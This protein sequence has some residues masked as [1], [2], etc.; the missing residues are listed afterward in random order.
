VDSP[1]R[2][3]HLHDARCPGS[4]KC[5]SVGCA[6]RWLA[7]LR[8]AESHGRLRDAWRRQHSRVAAKAMHEGGCV[9]QLVLPSLSECGRLDLQKQ[10][11]S[12][13]EGGTLVRRRNR[14]LLSRSLLPLCRPATWRWLLACTWYDHTTAVPSAPASLAAAACLTSSRPTC[15]PCH[16]G[17]RPACPS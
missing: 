10:T 14:F 15:C 13:S 9:L 4:S 8:A 2:H 16:A 6:C 5:K 17:G 11:T 1:G 3:Q 12:T 7:S